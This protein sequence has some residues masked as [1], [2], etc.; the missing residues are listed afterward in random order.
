[1]VGGK[2]EMTWTGGIV[3]STPLLGFIGEG[4]S[5]VALMV[6]WSQA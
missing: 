3:S 2:N 1:M 5:M 4:R 6:F